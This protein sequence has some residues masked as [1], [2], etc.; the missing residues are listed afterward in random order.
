MPERHEIETFLVL[1][2]ELHFGRTAERLHVST[3]RVSQTVR[4]LER[5][6]GAPLFARTSRRVEPTAI[7]RQLA[8]ELGPAWRAVG[9]AVQ[10]A[11]DAAHG[12]AGELRV[13]YAEP[14]AGQLLFGVAELFRARLARWE[15]VLREAPLLQRLDLLRAGE[16][17]LV[18]AEFPLLSPELVMGPVLVSEPRMLAVP[19]GHRLAEAASVAPEDLLGVP[20]VRLPADLPE[21][22]RADRGPGSVLGGGAPGDLSSGGGPSDAA[23]GGG[24]SGS[25]APRGAPAPRPSVG[26]ASALGPVGGT[27][28]EVLMLVGAGLGVFP[29]GAQTRRY[30][31]RPDVVYRPLAG[32]APVEWGLLWHRDRSTA[33]G[34]AFVR[35][36]QELLGAGEPDQL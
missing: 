29:V 6:V 23:P 24:P 14:A 25:V 34:R 4:K 33:A 3:A 30:H 26:E 28:N 11:T 31:A 2:E 35:A 20:F 13:A 8:E 16:V 21:S 19:A 1:S 5:R 7:G 36:A 17:D 12:Q 9:A 10:R 18:F 15:V 32:A 27:L 22:F